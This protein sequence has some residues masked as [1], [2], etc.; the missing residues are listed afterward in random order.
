MLMMFFRMKGKVVLTTSKRYKS[1]EW[2]I[3]PSCTE[4][5]SVSLHSGQMYI[6][7]KRWCRRLTLGGSL[8][9]HVDLRNCAS[10]HQTKELVRQTIFVCN[11]EMK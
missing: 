4:A 7:S 8:T 3:I 6:V 9:K 1:C 2:L 11:W 5:C 10:H